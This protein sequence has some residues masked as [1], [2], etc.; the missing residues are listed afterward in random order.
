MLV[1]PALAGHASPGYTKMYLKNAEASY[2]QARQQEQQG[3]VDDASRGYKEALDHAMSASKDPGY[4]ASVRLGGESLAT[5]GRRAIA[6]Q[7]KIVA[8]YPEDP[9]NEPAKLARI[10]LNK[11][12]KSMQKL[13]TNNPTWFY[14]DA[15][16]MAAKQ[17]YMSA[18]LILDRALKCHGGS[19]AVKA[20]CRKLLSHIGSAGEQQRKWYVADNI[21]RAE[22]FKRSYKPGLFSSSSS[23]YCPPEDSAKSSSSTPDYERR[24]RNAESQGD[25]GAAA[26]FRGGGSTVGDSSTYW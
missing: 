9:N 5:V 17:N 1:V 7:K 13:E 3:I 15:V 21:K 18:S 2:I 12:Y 4:L 11:L 20:K 19:E 16:M 8:A 25:Y 14:L 10:H 23:I 24:A 22:E 6:L 26:R